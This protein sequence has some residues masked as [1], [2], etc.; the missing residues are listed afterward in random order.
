MNGRF[1]HVVSGNNLYPRSLG[2]ET[3]ERSSLEKA[4]PRRRGRMQRQRFF[5]SGRNFKPSAV[6]AQKFRAPQGSAKR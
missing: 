6:A 1:L 2:Y 3:G 5:R 4:L